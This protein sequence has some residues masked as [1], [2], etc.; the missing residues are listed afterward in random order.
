LNRKRVAR[1]VSAIFFISSFQAGHLR[2]VIRFELDARLDHAAKAG[3][4]LRDKALVK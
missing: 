3:Q 2:E 1:V 4:P